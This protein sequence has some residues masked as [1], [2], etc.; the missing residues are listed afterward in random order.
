MERGKRVANQF[1]EV[2]QKKV[3]RQDL[4][5]IAA[6]LVSAAAFF[7]SF[8]RGKRE[9]DQTLRLQLDDA[10]AH[11]MSLAVDNAKLLHDEG[12]KDPEYYQNISQ[13]LNQQMAALVQQAIFLTRQIPNLVTSQHYQTIG[14]GSTAIGDSHTAGEF[15][16][17]AADLAPTGF[18]TVMALRT[19]AFYL[20][21]QRRFEEGR[22]QYQLTFRELPGSDTV[23]RYTNGMTYQV[24]A[25][26]ELNL[27]NN[28]GEAA[29]CMEKARAEFNGI[30]VASI[31]E[32]A[33]RAIAPIEA[34]IAAARR[35]T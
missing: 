17:K 15:F 4:I 5:S 20:F 22:A 30:D 27:A 9:R 32:N 13:A 31:K 23:C 16:H 28:P 25:F 10:L 26:N 3:E 33:L 12:A 29:A 2:R 1:L 11:I 6:L 21:Q 14:F 8:I 24:W 34:Q 19:Y 35:S 18:Y 7:V